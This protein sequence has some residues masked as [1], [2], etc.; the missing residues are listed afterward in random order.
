[1]AHV[2]PFRFSAP[3]G[4]LLLLLSGCCANNVCNC[5]DAVEDA[6]TLQFRYN[7]ADTLTAGNFRAADLDTIVLKRYALPRTATSKFDSLTVIRPAARA[8]DS[9]LITSNSPF[10]QAGAT[11]ISGY[12]YV[13]QYLAHPPKKGGGVTVLTINR[14]SLAG[15]FAGDGCCTCY[16]NTRK[17]VYVNNLS[18]PQDLTPKNAR[19][20]IPKR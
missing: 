17:L 19:L 11:K 10:A 20:L 13:V 4:L 12:S 7:P 8:G 18:V 1:M 14:T 16:L 2:L 9:L 5:N 3:W 6:I 15:T